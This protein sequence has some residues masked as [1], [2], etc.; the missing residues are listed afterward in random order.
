MYNVLPILGEG[1]AQTLAM[2]VGK[3][4]RKISRANLLSHHAHF[5]LSHDEAQALLEEVAG[6]ADELKAYYGKWLVG[7]D[8][9][10]ACDAVSSVRMRS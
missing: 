7:T 8:L 9:H 1:P 2:A 5:A 4:G 6:W 3:E 10:M